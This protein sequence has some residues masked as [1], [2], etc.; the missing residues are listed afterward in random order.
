MYP[1]GVTGCNKLAFNPSLK[2]TPDTTEADSP[3]GYGVDLHVPQSIAPND[4][5]SP[6]LDNAVATLPQGLAIN[7]GAADGLQACTDNG[8]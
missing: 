1:A 4:L 2:V 5:A 6:A 8:A 7:P 3:S